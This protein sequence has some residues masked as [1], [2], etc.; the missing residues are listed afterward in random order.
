M[1]FAAGRIKD[2]D[3]HYQTVYPDVQQNREALA[4]AKADLSKG[5]S[6]WTWKAWTG[7]GSGTAFFVCTAVLIGCAANGC[8][9][10]P[11]SAPQTYCQSACSVGPLIAGEV[12]SGIIVAIAIAAMTCCK[13]K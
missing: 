8:F 7:V 3:G 4:K 13:E 10:N 11:P 6:K 5:T 9:D 2:S 1:T 12:V